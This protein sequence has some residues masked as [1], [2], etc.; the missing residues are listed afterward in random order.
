ML[1]PSTRDLIRQ[2]GSTA[3]DK[4][5]PCMNKDWIFPMNTENNSARS[6]NVAA[7]FFTT[8]SSA[9]TIAIALLPF[10]TGH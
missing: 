5:E 8:L 7:V 10:V 4:V 2:V 3:S 1:I 9:T 6:E